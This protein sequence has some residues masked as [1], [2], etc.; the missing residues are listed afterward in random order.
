MP[1][2]DIGAF[3]LNIPAFLDGREQ[4]D[5]DE[6]VMSQKIA[7][8]RIHV[9]R[10]ITRIKKFKILK[11]EIPLNLNGTINQLWTVACLLCNFMDPLIKQ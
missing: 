8:V 6:V 10:A 3:Q 5:K 11:N 4:L 1:Y 2:T 9:E 7:S